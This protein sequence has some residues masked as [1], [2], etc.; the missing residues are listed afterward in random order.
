MAKGATVRMWRRTLFVLCFLF[1]SGFIIVAV[2]L[3]KLQIIDG[4]KLQKMAIDQQLK[5]TKI[6]AQRGTIYDRNMKPLA[7][8]ATVWTVVLEPAYLKDDSER[9]VVASGLSKILDMDEEDLLEKAQK[10]SYYMV[11][12]RKVDSETKDKIVEFKKNNKISSGVRLIEDHKRYYLYKNFLASVL[13]FTGT[14]GQGLAGLEEYYND[15]LT[16]EAGRVV[17]AKNALGTDMPFDYEQMIPAKNGCS[18]ILSIDESIQHFMEKNL[19]QGILDNKVKNRAAAVMMNVKTGEILGLAVKG[20]FDPN[21]PFKIYDQEEAQRIDALSSEEKTKERAIA[22]EKQWRNKAVSDTYYPGSV[23]KIIT[24]SMAIEEN[25][26]SENTMFTCSGGIHP[27]PGAPLV[28]CWKKS[29]HGSETFVQSVCNSCN[30]VFMMLGQSLGAEK[31]YR[32]YKAFGFAEKTG[33]D[34]PGEAKDIF[35][36]KDGSMAPMDLVVASFGQNFSITPIQMLTAVCA[37]ANGGNLV[38]PHIVDRIIDD[39]GNIVKSFDTVVKRKVISENT[40]KRVCAILHTNA[41]IGTAKNGY[42]AGYRIAGKTGTSEKVGLSRSGGM[43]YIS[44][45]CGFAPAD[46]PQVALI[47]YFDTPTGDSH[48]GGAV[49]GPAFANIM[50]EV[51]PYLGIEKKY[52]EEEAKNLEVSMPNLI[53]MEVYKAKEEAQ[54]LSLRAIVKGNGKNVIKQI[55]EGSK[56]VPKGGTVVLYTDEDSTNS[57]VIVPNF[58]GLSISEVN[59]LAGDSDINVVIRG[60]SEGQDGIIAKSQS[61]KEGTRVTSGSIVVVD[62]IQVDEVT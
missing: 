45:Y 39:N 12:K 3:F 59:K 35:F 19:E 32:Y 14:D 34:L 26:V 57:T 29:G 9:K 55:P 49:A 8:S 56:M 25:I 53:G 44:S 27:Y 23:W 6:S 50:K 18:L 46:D 48:Y 20:D 30:P 1:M 62:F 52:T 15:Y 17:T 47:V 38:K 42:V 37:V 51:L 41:T 10:K 13:G 22:W 33:I 2:R 43:D 36:S 7:Q 24:S 31:F 54:R 28:R 60:A 5:D 11:V 61:I 21:E 4:A 16:G 40:A 58:V